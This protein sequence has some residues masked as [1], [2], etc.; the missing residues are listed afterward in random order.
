M[1]LKL[2]FFYT[3]EDLKRHKNKIDFF[4]FYLNLIIENINKEIC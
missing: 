2:N 4:I 3:L 1:Y